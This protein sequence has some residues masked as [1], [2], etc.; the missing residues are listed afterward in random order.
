M[1]KVLCQSCGVPMEKHGDFGTTK[2]G[3]SN[4]TYCR[5]CFQGGFFTNPHATMQGQIDKMTSIE[6]SKKNISEYDAKKKFTALMPT[7]DRWKNTKQGSNTTIDQKKKIKFSIFSAIGVL[8]IVVA[9][10]IFSPEGTLD[11]SNS[12]SDN[13]SSSMIPIWIALFVTFVI[14]QKKKQWKNKQKPKSEQ[15]KRILYAI[16]LLTGLLVA[17]TMIFIYMKNNG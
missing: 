5:N 16:F 14:G 7:L 12:D 11:S 3:K 17:G 9:M 13:D 4:G 10:Y 15:Q 2:D 1:Q 8:L 6:M